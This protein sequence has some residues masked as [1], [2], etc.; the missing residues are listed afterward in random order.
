MEKQE[1]QTILDKSE[2]KREIEKRLKK[3]GYHNTRY[4]RP[5]KGTDLQQIAK[6]CTEECDE[7]D[8]KNRWLF[9][10][11]GTYNGY[12]WIWLEQTMKSPMRYAVSIWA[13]AQ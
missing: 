4:F 7:A 9:A 13:K 2:N 8:R 12:E 5:T 1:L 10:S 6:A 11:Q 3:A